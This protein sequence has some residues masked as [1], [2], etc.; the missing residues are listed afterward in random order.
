MA[1]TL[2]TQL[3]VAVALT[4][5]EVVPLDQPNASPPGTYTTKRATAGQIAGLAASSALVVNLQTGT[6]YVTQST[7]KAALISLSNAAPVAVTLPAIGTGG[8]LV[9]PTW[10]VQ[11]ENRGAG[12]VTISPAGAQTIDGAA[13]IALTQHQGVVI[14]VGIDGNWYTQRGM[15]LTAATAVTSVGLALPASLFSVTGSPVTTTGTLTG[16]LVT[17]TAN[18]IWAGPTTGA[19]A[20][21]TF[22]ALVTADLPN[23]GTAATYGSASTVPVITTDAKGRVTAT[24]A[25]I[26][27]GSIG[28]VAA[29]S[30]VGNATGAPAA[31]TAISIGATF[32]FSGTTLQT[33][34]GTGDVTW[35]ANSYATTIA[36]NVVSYAKFQQVAALSVVGN[37]TNAL[38]NAAAITAA[39]DGQVLRRSGTAVGFGTIDLTSANAV[40]GALGAGNGGTGQSTYTIGDLLYASGTGALSKLADV[41]TGN[42]LISGGVGVAPSW[43]KIALTTHVS[44]TLPVANGGTGIATTT[45]YSLICAGTTATGA[46]QS[47]A[48]IG[49]SGQVLTSA[50]AGALPTWQSPA[51]TPN[52]SVINSAYAEYTAGG[53]VSAAIPIDDT[54]PQISEGT[55]IMS[56]TLTPSSVTSK[57]RITVTG[58]AAGSGTLW[59]EGAVFRNSV[60]NALGSQAI[61][62]PQ[63]DWG[64]TISF[65]TEFTPGVTTL[66]TYTVRV[67]PSSGNMYL[68][69]IATGR[70]HGG[71]M[72]WTM[73]VQE[74]KA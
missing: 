3:P 68:N 69:A 37:G 61:V 40:T 71:A 10:F 2:I 14:G 6:S 27:P 17:Q 8:S 38:A 16:A 44:G 50:G 26:V 64:E 60:A 7:D 67:G 72:K 45:A 54:I 1:D 5:S 22:R 21:P 12:L 30:L 47:L 70:I 9:G 59:L 11:Y 29:S 35:S 74:I 55:Q 42:A 18:F 51:V 48:S 63:S 24:T 15:G 25:A 23:Y 56:T 52:G 65:T 36:A 46:F 13:S 62:T 39:S 4:G 31:A 33:L 41:A 58:M 53:N 34:A 19:A 28:S 43:G 57:V 32:Q 20:T 49:T 66:E 73:V